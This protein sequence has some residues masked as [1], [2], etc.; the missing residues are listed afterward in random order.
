MSHGGMTKLSLVWM[1]LFAGLQVVQPAVPRS[2]QVPLHRVGAGSDCQGKENESTGGGFQ[3]SGFIC[4][5][6]VRGQRSMHAAIVISVVIT[7]LI[8]NTQTHHTH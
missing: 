5:L 7:T 1:P 3:G 8:P 4:C 6:Q 2:G